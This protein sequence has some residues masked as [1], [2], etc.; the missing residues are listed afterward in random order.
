MKE[1]FIIGIAGGSGSGKTTLSNAL[2]S[3]LE[4]RK[5]LL[6]EFD[7]YYRDLSHIPQ[8]RR[9]KVNFDHP[10]ALDLEMFGEHLSHLKEFKPIKK[11]VYNFNKHSRFDDYENIEPKSFIITEGILLFFNKEIRKCIDFKIFLDIETN[12][13]FN[14]RITRDVAKRQRTPESVKKQYYSTVEPMHKQF[15]EPSKR[16]AD[17]ILKD[18]DISNWI[19]KII[20]ELSCRGLL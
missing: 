6:F 16:Y 10:D 3:V 11:P 19:G 14:R 18:D 13:R 12:T 7:D 15:V 2:Q 4:P 9:D 8:E 17:L 20:S 5:S 1:P